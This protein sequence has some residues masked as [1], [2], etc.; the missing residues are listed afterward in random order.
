M[1]RKK[2]IA[3]FKTVISWEMGK[4]GSA[5]FA[6]QVLPIA[7]GAAEALGENPYQ[8]CREVGFSEQLVNDERDKRAS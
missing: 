4:S 2:L 8:F 1:D 7:W 6:H 5:L 3:A